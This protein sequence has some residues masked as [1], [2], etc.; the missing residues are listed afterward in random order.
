MLRTTVLSAAVTMFVAFPSLAAETTPSEVDDEDSFQ[1]VAII[2][3]N[4]DATAPATGPGS[5]AEPITAD[6]W[7]LGS[8]KSYDCK[9]IRT[10]ALLT[11]ANYWHYRANAHSDLEDLLFN[12]WDDYSFLIEDF[13][14]PSVSMR[15]LQRATVQLTAVYAELCNKELG[16][17]VWTYG[18]PCHYG[19]AGLLQH[20]RIDKILSPPL[21]RLTGEAN[22]EVLA[23]LWRAP[24][25][26]SE[27]PRLREAVL[28]WITAAQ[29]GPGE[30]RAFMY[31]PIDNIQ[32]DQR[33]SPLDPNTW[34]NFVG[35]P[36]SPLLKLPRHQ[37]DWNVEYF[38]S[39]D[40]PPEEWSSI[41][42]V[43]ACV[44]LARDC[45]DRWPL[46]PSDTD[47]MWGDYICADAEKDDG[48][49]SIGYA[50]APK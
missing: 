22:R 47:Y 8:N 1:P 30:Y 11:W 13:A 4:C 40:E 9:W 19:P 33:K 49:W 50:P 16:D 36:D 3:K 29:K 31:G 17:N 7:E 25:G 44:C 23:Q 27:L 20:V 38:H 6:L 10:E 48:V 14:E 32:E 43:T 37:R 24:K 12:N 41:E 15:D 18:G 45:E 42:D 39:F 35:G 5:A 26:W 21:R 28:N 46:L 34:G 2:S